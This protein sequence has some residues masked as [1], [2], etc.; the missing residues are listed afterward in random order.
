[1][2]ANPEEIA[3]TI[4]DLERSLNERWSVGDCSGYLDNF[5]DD[6]SY[7]DPV[8]DHLLVGREN[9]VNHIKGIYKN[10]N[11]VRN[12]YL[13]PSVVVSESADLAVLSYNLKTFIHDTS[14][15][16]QPLREWNSTEVY[17][18]I[19]G[20]WRLIHS[21]WGLTKSVALAIAS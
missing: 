8:V 18:F 20:Q 7:F 21:N 6:I 16:E 11:I 5:S 13:N 2:K 14:G 4:L 12:E 3:S 19:E 9:V 10:P 17:R 15:I 1:M